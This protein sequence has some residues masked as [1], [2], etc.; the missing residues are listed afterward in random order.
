MPTTSL[1]DPRL[2]VAHVIAPVA[3]G[4][5]LSE[6]VRQAL[7]FARERAVRLTLVYCAEPSLQQLDS[8][9]RRLA[10]LTG[11]RECAELHVR[12]LVR[13]GRAEDALREICR[14]DPGYVFAGRF[15]G[16]DDQFDCVN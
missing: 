3:A 6:S 13:H 10:V 16:L 11:G 14:R 5:S 7:A 2:R 4:S 9:M 12:V 15:E 8:A 1:E